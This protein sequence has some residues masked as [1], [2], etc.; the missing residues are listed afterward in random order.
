MRTSLRPSTV[1]VA[2]AVAV[3]LVAGCAARPSSRPADDLTITTHVKTALLNDPEITA[4]R[5]DV[6]TVKGVV[7]LSGRVANRQEEQRAIDVARKVPGVSDVKSTLK[8]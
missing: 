7:T 2:C 1:F 4:P 3:S 6:E 8:W 5:I